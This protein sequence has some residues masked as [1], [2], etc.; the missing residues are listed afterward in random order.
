VGTFAVQIARAA[1]AQVFATCGAYDED[2][3][4]ELGAD[5]TVDYRAGSFVEAVLDRTDGAGVDVALDTVGGEV[6]ED[7]VEVTAPGGRIVSLIGEPADLSGA[8]PR[9]LDVHFVFLP[10][11]GARLERL[12]AVVDR[13]LVEPV[14]DRTVGLDQV[15]EA[16]AA[17]AEGRDVAGKI[18]VDADLTR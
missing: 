3:V 4:A 8:N 16:H 1:G 5:H 15:P 2:L 6:L 18:A 9:N 11:S 7:T 17:L 10:R 13:G 14:V 12:A